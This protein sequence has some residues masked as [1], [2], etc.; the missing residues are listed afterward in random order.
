MYALH[1]CLSKFRYVSYH[2]IFLQN[3]IW[4]NDDVLSTALTQFTEFSLRNFSYIKSIKN[5]L[6]LKT[7]LLLG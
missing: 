7:N 3:F 2:S 5:L 4:T 1:P 6:V